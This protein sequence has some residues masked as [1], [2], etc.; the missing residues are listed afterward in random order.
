MLK[1]RLS[2]VIVGLL[3][4]SACSSAP[5]TPPQSLTVR[6]EADG[7]ILL[8]TKM[9]REGQSDAAR[10]YYTEAYRMYTLVDEP[11]GRIRALEGLGR[12]QFTDF[13]AWEK[14]TQIAEDSGDETL[15]ALTSLLEAEEL[16]I[17]GDTDSREQ[18]LAILDRAI[19]NLEN[20]PFDKARAL[21]LFGSLL[22]QGQRYDEAVSNLQKAI[23]MDTKNRSYI[24]LASDY[25]L[26]ASVYSKKGEYTEALTYLANAVEYDRRAENGSGLGSDYMALGIV[27]EKSGNKNKA[28]ISYQKA[29]D[30]FT[31]GRLPEKMDEVSKRITAL[32]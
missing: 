26:L 25:Y 8:G 31:A 20:R 30:I 11:E 7:F 2:T 6:K 29:L 12:V 19:A 18:A 27:Y 1:Q 17:Y 23:D 3:L 5:K 24:D 28:R 32:E 15:I 13:D 21:R 22:K 14:A 10:E 16:L 9:L 4:L